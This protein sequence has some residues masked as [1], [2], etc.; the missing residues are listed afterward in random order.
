MDVD[1][2]PVE[3]HA[4]DRPPEPPAPGRPARVDDEDVRAGAA[5]R[6][7]AA[8]PTAGRRHVTV[9]G[10]RATAD[11]AEPMRRLCDEWHPDAGRARVVRGNRNAHTPGALY[12]APGPA[13]ARRRAARVEFRD[14][15]EHAPRRNTAERELSAR[16]RPCPGRRTPDAATPGTPGN[17]GQDARNRDGV[18]IH[19]CFRVAD[20]RKTMAKVY[21]Q[22][23]PPADH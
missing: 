13:E 20:A 8:D 22:Q 5:N 18:E 4:D 6:F 2:C 9:T 7:V 12:G 10:R 1:E 15:P 16:A 3:R 23:T 21:P 17:A 11:V 19:G 14:T